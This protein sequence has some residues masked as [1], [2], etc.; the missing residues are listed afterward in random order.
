MAAHETAPLLIN[1][2]RDSFDSGRSRNIIMMVSDGHGPASQ[3]YARSF[4][5]Y[6]NQTYKSKKPYVS[7]LDRIL[8][9]TSRTRASNTLVT[10]SA[11]G[12]TAFSC[13]IKTYN[14]A[15]GVDKHGVPC[16]TILEA[17]KDLG[18]LTG[19]VVTNRV[20]DATPASFSSHVLHRGME[21][22]IAVQQIGDY[23]LGRQLDLLMGGGLCSF[24]PN[25]TQ[26]SC[27]PDNRNLIEERKNFGWSDTLMLNRSSFD[28]YDQLDEVEDPIPLPALGL[29]SLG[30]MNYEIDR[31]PSKE[32]SLEEMTR[33]ALKFLKRNADS[34]QGFFLMIEG[35]RIDIA[36]HYND[37]AAHV[38]EILQ[39]HRA[40]AVVRKFVADN[41][42][43]LLISTSDHETGGFTLGSQDDPT[44]D[45]DYFWRPEAIVPVKASTEI[46]AQKIVNYK[47]KTM[48]DRLH[49][50]KTEILEKNLGIT[51]PT[52]EELSYLSDP[53]SLYHDIIVFLGHAV[54]RRALLGWTT[55]GHTGVDVNLYAEG[56]NDAVK[57]L[58]GNRENTDIGA[59]MSTFLHVDLDYIT[60]KLE[61]D[62]DKWFKSTRGWL[63][64]GDR[65]HKRTGH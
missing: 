29:F 2:E 38:H 27:R 42:D 13:G 52:H 64:G 32:P 8:V 6:Y 51:D 34:N 60:K 10:D 49:F 22:D 31:D 5:P 15:I 63:Y 11:A 45:P 20:T 17:A 61:K 48:K 26:G 18:M 28:Y 30:D 16:G 53:I 21:A 62:V 57:E 19:M 55:L 43:T 58:R 37:P 65:H 50:V 41:P 56:D 40:V 3:T 9:G 39:Y 24:L 36:A 25:T 4:Y 54:S 1:E 44:R 46:L 7:P 14:G 59:T 47:G 33:G 23:V 12:A 35:S